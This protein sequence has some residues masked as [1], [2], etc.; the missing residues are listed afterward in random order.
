MGLCLGTHGK[1][2][3]RYRGSAGMGG[4]E[5]IPELYTMGGG[6]RLTAHTGRHASD[7]THRAASVLGGNRVAGVSRPWGEEQ[8]TEAQRRGFSEEP[9]GQLRGL[10]LG[11]IRA[12]RQQAKV[13]PPPPTS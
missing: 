7:L 4:P 8:Q 2:C 6:R 12:P 3:F 11:T 9:P 5:V 1:G 13:F 10:R